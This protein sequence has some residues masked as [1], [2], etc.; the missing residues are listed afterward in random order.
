MISGP[1]LPDLLSSQEFLSTIDFIRAKAL[2]A[3]RI[4]AVRPQLKNEQVFDWREAKHPLLYLA[5]KAE[6]KEVVPLSF[7]LVGKNPDPADLRSQ[8]RREIGLSED[9]RIAAVYAAMRLAGTLQ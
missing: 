2:F 1:I 3:I 4:E 5:H 8:C 6:Q 7:H 9:H